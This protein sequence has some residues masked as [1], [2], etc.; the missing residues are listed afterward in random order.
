MSDQLERVRRIL[1]KVT[2]KPGWLI[3]A[4]DHRQMHPNKNE[5]HS[6]YDM[7]RI[8]LRV[9]CMQPDTITGRNME[10][11]NHT[12]LSVFDLSNLKDEQVVEYFITRAIREMELHEM[13]EW[14]KYDGT[15]VRDPHPGG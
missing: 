2:Y 5:S 6:F 14:F 9:L 10:I 15:H 1:G 4:F 11:V 8:Y 3:T 12:S 7:N 13:D